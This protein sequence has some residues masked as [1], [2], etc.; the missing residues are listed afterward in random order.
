MTD[1]NYIGLMYRGEDG[2]EA[3]ESNPALQSQN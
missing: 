3:E 1:E 2:G